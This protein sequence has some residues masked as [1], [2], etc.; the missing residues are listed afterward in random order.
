MTFVYVPIVLF[1]VVGL[2]FTFISASSIKPSR[3]GR[4]EDKVKPDYLDK[5][6]QA[7]EKVK[8]ESKMEIKI[9]R[10]SKEDRDMF[11]SDNKDF[12]I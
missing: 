8:I 12:E 2:I 11:I 1:V 9:K 5:M 7:P 4:Y 6:N 10:R 3:A